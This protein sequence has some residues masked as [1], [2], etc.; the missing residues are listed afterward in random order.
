MIFMCCYLYCVPFL[1][2]I[3]SS[4]VRGILLIYMFCHRL[5][6]QKENGRVIEI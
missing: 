5:L 3:T 4:G 1:L 6:I 2:L